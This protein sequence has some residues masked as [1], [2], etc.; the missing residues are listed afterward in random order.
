MYFILLNTHLAGH[1]AQMFP[2]LH[3]AVE[4][5]RTPG[6]RRREGG[7]GGSVGEGEGGQRGSRAARIQVLKVFGFSFAV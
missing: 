4:G 1:G 3:P 2:R 6:G 7:V 5:D